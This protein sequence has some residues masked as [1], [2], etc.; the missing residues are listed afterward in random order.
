VLLAPRTAVIRRCLGWRLGGR[1]AYCGKA[2]G[3]ARASGS[4]IRGG[5]QRVSRQMALRTRRKSTCR[6]TTSSGSVTL[7]TSG[8]H[9][10]E[11]AVQDMSGM[12][13]V[14]AVT[15]SAMPVA[16]W[17]ANGL[18]PI[19]GA[20][21][22][23]IPGAAKGLFPGPRRAYRRGRRRAHP[24]GRPKGLFADGWCQPVP[25]RPW[26]AGPQVL[27]DRTDRRAGHQPWRIQL[28]GGSDCEDTDSADGTCWQSHQVPPGHSS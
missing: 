9:V 6:R 8:S 17:P 4:D 22:G 18:F 27:P 24:R 25:I 2:P 28:T 20:A 15:G 21:E 1:R 11:A 3:I 10:T 19:P 14:R 12:W 13:T 16:T 26:P 7:I 23:P 5:D